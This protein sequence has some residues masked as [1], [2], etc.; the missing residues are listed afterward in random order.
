MNFMLLNIAVHTQGNFVMAFDQLMLW[1]LCV[2]VIVYV[3]VCMF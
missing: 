2:R 3:C 1:C